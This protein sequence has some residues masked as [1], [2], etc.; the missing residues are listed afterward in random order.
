M[1]FMMMSIRCGMSMM[2]ELSL[3]IKM[4]IWKEGMKKIF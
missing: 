2:M 1:I 4:I 3:Y